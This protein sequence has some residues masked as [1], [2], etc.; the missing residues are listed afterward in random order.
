MQKRVKEPTQPTLT[1]RIYR[2]SLLDVSDHKRPESP[3]S[4]PTRMEDDSKSHN[5]VA[6]E[7]FQ[8]QEGWRRQD[9]LSEYRP[10]IDNLQYCKLYADSRLGASVKNRQHRKLSVVLGK[11]LGICSDAE[12]LQPQIGPHSASSFVLPK[13]LGDVEGEPEHSLQFETKQLTTQGLNSLLSLEFSA[14]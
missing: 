6:L 5:C 8:N 12:G 13:I 10:S 2:R 1:D 14:E 4:S 9:S 11:Q 3:S 7:S